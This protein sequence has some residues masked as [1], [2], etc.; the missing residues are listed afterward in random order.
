MDELAEITGRSRR[1]LTHWHREDPHFFGI[2]LDGAAKWRT[3]G[4]QLQLT[5]EQTAA[6]KRLGGAAW[7]RNVI[8]MAGRE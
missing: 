8:D 1:T 6:F 3:G 2:V 7:M 4:Y 5:P